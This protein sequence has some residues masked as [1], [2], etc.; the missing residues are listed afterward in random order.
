MTLQPRPQR[1][2]FQS[3][4]KEKEG[5]GRKRLR[6]QTITQSSKGGQSTSIA[7]RE[8]EKIETLF[9]PTIEVEVEVDTV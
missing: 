9:A 4:V 2:S 6:H 1:I 7:L 5:G 8:K 3:R